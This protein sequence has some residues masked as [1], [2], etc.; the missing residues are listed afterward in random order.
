MRMGTVAGMFILLFPL[1]L[2]AQVRVERDSTGQI[3]ITNKGSKTS[4]KGS[5]TSSGHI[6]PNAGK[7]LP[8]LSPQDTE[9]IKSKLRDACA[10]QGLD[11]SLV[12]ALV[13][14]E[15]DFRPNVL[16]N[17]GA[18]GL[19]QLMPDTARRFGVT[20]PWDVDQNI[21]GG[22]AFL[23]FLKDTFNNDVPLM[24]AG[25]NA[26]ENAVMK[27]SNKIPPYSDTVRYVFTIL[28]DYG[29]PSLVEK[30]KK[31]LATPGDYDE[32]YVARKSYRPTMRVFYMFF[33]SKGVRT[34]C[35]TQPVGVNY[36][37]I[38]YKDDWY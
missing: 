2:T 23:K 10:R 26:G 22:T 3:V 7:P 34:I 19:M 20:N 15:S 12:S 38:V 31:Q 4:G 11:F 30:A 25:Y 17:K 24:L 32:Y 28:H 1:V 8:P 33:N 29:S 35:D 27:Y 13:R 21:Q 36:T 6:S 14:A 37:Q 16:S 5:A 18:I 9:S